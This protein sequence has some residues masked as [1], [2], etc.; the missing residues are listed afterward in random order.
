MKRYTTNK[1]APWYLN[2]QVWNFKRYKVASTLFFQVRDHI[3]SALLFFMVRNI[4][5]FKK[6]R[7]CCLFSFEITKINLS[8]SHTP[9]FFQVLTLFWTQFFS[10]SQADPWF[11][12]KN[13]GYRLTGGYLQYIQSFH[14]SEVP[15]YSVTNSR[16]FSE[17]S[18]S[19][20]LGWTE[21][22]AENSKPIYEVC[23]SDSVRNPLLCT[24][25]RGPL[26]IIACSPGLTNLA[27]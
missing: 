5:I 27:Q 18:P 8:T 24:V 12:N 20:Y 14:A 17:V 4:A 6:R 26:Y 23:D 2:Y 9:T 3:F 15:V 19:S 1:S 13:S 11:Q 21:G 16:F 7:P 25:L 10:G 22:L